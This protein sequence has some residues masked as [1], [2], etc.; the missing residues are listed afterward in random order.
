ML[1]N[2]V[3]RRFRSR[4]AAWAAALFLAVFLAAPAGAA[5][6]LVLATGAYAPYT[7][8]DLPGRG[9][10]TEILTRA[11]ERAGRVGFT[12]ANRPLAVA[13]LARDGQPVDALRPALG[14]TP[15]ESKPFRILVSRRWPGAV[16]LLARLNNALTTMRRDGT[17]DRIV[18]RFH[19]RLRAG[20][21][22]Q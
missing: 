2:P 12:V 17:H 6:T 3:F 14:G 8:R 21:K 16:D 5:E 11:L 1:R 9:M 22:A 7:G 15:V 18:T 13:L 4:A 19:Q 10:A 20:E